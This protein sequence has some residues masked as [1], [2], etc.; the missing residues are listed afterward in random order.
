MTGG[1]IRRAAH[2]AVALFAATGV[3]LHYVV[4]LGH[5]GEVAVRSIRFLSYFTILT[6]ILVAA[7]AFAI[8][9]GGERLAA[10]AGRPAW[11]TMVTLDILVVALIY[12][13]LLRD[14]VLPGAI[15]WWANTLVHQIVPAAWTACWLAFAP[16]GAIDR[17]APLRWLLYPLGYALWTLVHGAVGG[18]YPYPFM[19][20][21]KLGYPAVLANVAGIGLLFLA[22]G[23][24]LRW[25]DGRLA[26]R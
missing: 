1:S 12:H 2:G 22:L 10:P 20:V 5:A 13:L 24:A 7:S 3:V 4:V 9:L 19:D 18:W 23:H 17:T 11:R 25:A 21:G 6:N 15:G 26:R 14:V 8:A 16:H